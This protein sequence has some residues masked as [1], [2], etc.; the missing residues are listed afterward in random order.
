MEQIWNFPQQQ[1]STYGARDD[2]EAASDWETAS[3]GDYV[4]KQIHSDHDQESTAQC[5]PVF[6]ILNEQRA[7]SICTNCWWNETNIW[8]AVVNRIRLLGKAVEQ[9]KTASFHATKY[10]IVRAC[11]VAALQRY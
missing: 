4:T 9:T 11:C 5:F 3:D 1:Q 7:G 10:H 8:M 6:I 2:Y